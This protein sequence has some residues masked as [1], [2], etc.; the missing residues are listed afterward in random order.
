MA[1]P[2]QTAHSPTAVDVTAGRRPLALWLCLVGLLLLA[3]LLIAPGCERELVCEGQENCPGDSACVEGSC[4]LRACFGNADC[5][6]EQF[7]NM[8][9]GQCEAGCTNDKDCY[10][11]ATCSGG[12]CVEKACTSSG[13]DCEAG[14]YCDVYT[15][16]CYD[17][18]GPFCEPC[19]VDSDCGGGNNQCFFVSGEGPYCLPECDANRPCPAGYSCVPIS[20]QGSPSFFVCVTLCHYLEDL[21]ANPRMSLPPAVAPAEI[22][23]VSR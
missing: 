4:Q 1:T 9:I 23:G 17:A 7:C 16:E 2:P 10:F 20:R 21:E 3:G 15:G 18:A 5:P 19:S 14:Q 12:S 22:G 11:G 6:M 13:L 8:D